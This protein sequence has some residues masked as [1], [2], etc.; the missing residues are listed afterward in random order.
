MRILRWIGIIFVLFIIFNA[1]AAAQTC[2]QPPPGLVAWWSAEGN[3]NDIEGSNHA[4]QGNTIT[5]AA[6]MVG[7]AFHFDDENDLIYVGDFDSL[8]F[9]IPDSF[10]ISAWIKTSYNGGQTI[11]SKALTMNPLTGIIFSQYVNGALA[12]RL[13]AA[14]STA[15][16][17]FRVSDS[18][19]NDD[20]W[21]FVAAS[22]DG[23]ARRSSIKLYIDGAR[24]TDRD[25]SNGDFSGSMLNQEPV[26]IGGYIDHFQGL[27]DET[28]IFSRELSEGEIQDIFL[29]GAAGMCNTYNGNIAP[30]AVIDNQALVA[31]GESIAINA[32]NSIDPDGNLPLSYYWILKGKPEGSAA[33]LT[34]GNSANAS[35]ITDLPGGYE[36]ELIVTD[37]AGRISAPETKIVSAQHNFPAGPSTGKIYWAEWISGS[38]A[39]IRS[40]DIDGSDVQEIA[41]VFYP[42]FMDL[43][44][45]EQKLYWGR[46]HSIERMNTDGTGLETVSGAYIYGIEIDPFEKKIYYTNDFNRKIHSMNLD[47]TGVQELVAFTGLG[48]VKD[49]DLDHQNGKMYWADS[50]SNKLFRANLNGSQVEEIVNQ[51]LI[52]PWGIGLD[53]QN[54]RIYFADAGSGRIQRCNLNGT[55]LETLVNTGPADFSSYYNRAPMG[56]ELD[57]NEG[58][59]Y[60]TEYYGK[61]LKRANLDGSDIQTLVTDDLNF[62]D[63]LALDLGDFVPDNEQPIAN[64]GHDQNIPEG[65]LVL[66]DG[67]GSSD[68]D[69]NFPLTYTWEMISRPSGSTAELSAPDGIT[70]SF[71]PDHTGQ[72]TIR[73]TITDDLGLASDPDD[74]VVTVFKAF[75]L[76]VTAGIHAWYSIDS[77]NTLSEG[78]SVNIWNNRIGNSNFDLNALGPNIPTYTASGYNGGP[79]VHFSNNTPM[80]TSNNIG[81][82]GDP[83]FTVFFVGAIINGPSYMHP[84]I[85]GDGSGETGYAGG[86][87]DFEIQDLGGGNRRVDYATGHNRD[88]NT[89]YG[90]FNGLLGQPVT[91]TYTRS[92]GPLNLTTQI[93]INGI[94]QP[95]SGSSESPNIANT[96]FYVGPTYA[97]Y[98]ASSPVMDVA[99]ILMYNRALSLQEV[100]IVEAYLKN[101]NQVTVNVT[102]SKGRALSNVTVYAFDESGGYAG[103]SAVTDEHGVAAFDAEN[104]SA[105]NYLFRAD[106]LSHQFWSPVISISGANSTAII[107]E[108]ETTEVAV[109]VSGEDKEGI[110]VYLFNENGSYLGVYGLTDSTGTVR[111]DLPADKIFQFRAD[112]L[113]NQ[114]WSGPVSVATGGTNYVNLDTGG[115]LLSVAVED[116]AGNPLPGIKVF[117]FNTSGSYLGF[118]GTTDNNGEVFFTVS[119]GLYK[120]RANYSGFQFWSSQLTIDSDETYSLTIPH[121]EVTVT[122]TGDYAGDVL[123]MVNYKVY[124]FTAA[125]S[126]LARYEMTDDHGQVIFNLP[127]KDYKFRADY[128]A[129]QYWSEPL[130]WTDGVITIEEGTA[131]VTVTNM[132]FPAQDVSVYTFSSSGSYL[133]VTGVSNEVGKVEFRLPQGDYKFRAD[134]M[135]DQYWSG[136]TT[137]VAHVENPIPI[138]TGGGS[139]GLT[140]QKGPDEPLAGVNCYLFSAAGSYLGEHQVSSGEGDISFNLADGDYKIRV[141]HLGYQFWTDPFSIPEMLSQTITIEHQDVMVTVSGDDGEDVEPRDNLKVYLFTPSGSYQNQYEVTDDLGQ[142]VFN[143]PAEDYKVR[144]DY[145]SQQYWSEDFNWEDV[146]ITI[147]EGIAE[148]NVSQ[149]GTPLE[150]VTVYVFNASGGYIGIQNQTDAGGV[151]SF[152]L[153]EA[154]YQ[155]R[156]DHLGDQFWTTKQVAAHQVTAIDIDTGGGSFVLTVEKAPG[157]P[158]VNVP[159]YAFTS[160]GS[161]LGLTAG[162]DSQGQVTFDLADGA[163]KFR[164]DYLGY[165]FWSDVATVPATL[166]ETLSVPHQ[167]VT[168]TVNE[169]YDPDVTPLA[170]IPVYLF[171]V[172]GSYLKVQAMTDVAGQVAFELPQEQYKA[173]ADYL[174]IKYWSELFNWTDTSVNIEHG[175]VILHV[176][177]NGQGIPDAPV[178]LFSGSGSYLG[179]SSSTDA[180]GDA[181]F[182]LPAD[183]F[184]FRLDFDG[185]Q[186]WSA[187]VDIDA[188][189]EIVIEI[190]LD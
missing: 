131:S 99:E 121:Q 143:L 12:L 128:L 5:Y 21:H 161:Y 147:E 20:Q 107:V 120:L 127:A 45:T 79:A 72:Y 8:Q 164:A 105:G 151:V 64:A 33:S 165:R 111:F 19:I 150:N 160:G 83:E 50:G 137:V 102:T 132:G 81:L 6:G 30:I 84:W 44:P 101:K 95:I 184:K 172:S 31:P 3:T 42:R 43:E 23:S 144:V 176:T 159:V 35:I 60:W 1:L 91:V 138:S 158:L 67:S 51:K 78:A 41:Q 142:V 40:A 104:F 115:G 94:N 57:I 166:T 125:G 52:E 179:R 16:L 114:Y 119:G 92:P 154:S 46:T 85:W 90:S 7:Q 22:Y 65:S 174:S 148:I 97:Q 163:Y 130:N 58:K 82:I 155:F 28:A 27:I 112:F 116:N 62:L 55:A 29:A 80:G 182:V 11:F 37:A 178:Y 86:A 106:Y 177:L 87:S 167:V 129:Q 124:M 134:H 63:S 71:T 89:P 108:E 18:T 168:V 74:V 169:A 186:Y 141:D 133:G 117:L 109:S 39:K 180:S 173:R 59:I 171:N 113:S 75:G 47:G 13:N 189:N 70:P 54:G 66:L 53:P 152:R 26:R 25:Y 181:S 185:A 24:V 140:V 157:S 36:I 93:I 17:I 73:L 15:H 96:P 149:G 2:I 123:P 188:H 136:I 98:G 32:Q 69:E 146:A 100:E 156:A 126:Y 187:I 162:T 110:K 77:L 10:T 9:D 49:I 38:D 61:S 175:M 170:G 145:Q 34:G 122:V 118:S 190:S 153:P 183:S 4:Y 56:L 14:H 76:P 139:F 88:A 135:G 48:L 103:L 68:P